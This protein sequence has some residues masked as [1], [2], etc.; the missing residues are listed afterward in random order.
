MLLRW[1]ALTLSVWV[2]TAIVPGIFCPRW[3][4]LL[5][6]ALVLGV[7]NVFVKPLLKLVS[8]PFILLTLGLFVLVINALLLLFTAWLVKGFHVAGFWSAV[9][10]SLVIS[11]VSVF[12]GLS[13]RP[14]RVVF[15]APPPQPP[16]RPQGPPPGRGPIIDV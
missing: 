15:H 5:V 12:L 8:L 13:G 9:G 10:G 2:A 1:M 11:V 4:D 3:Q 14:R 6:A 16:P 7:L